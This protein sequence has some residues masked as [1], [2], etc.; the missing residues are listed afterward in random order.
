M[1]YHDGNMVGSITGHSQRILLRS[2]QGTLACFDVPGI[3]VQ[4]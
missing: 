3:P 2:L 1:D 4:V